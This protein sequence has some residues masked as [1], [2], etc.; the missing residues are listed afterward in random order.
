MT[1]SI[2]KMSIDYYLEHAATGDGAT[3]DLTSYYTETKAP[4]GTWFG[5]G[6]T[7]LSGLQAGQKVS[8]YA[9]RAVYEDQA[10]PATGQQLGRPR[11][12]SQ[13]T[14]KGART[15]AG[16]PQKDQRDGVAGFDL[17]FSPPKSVSALWALAGPELQDRLHAAHRQATEETLRWVEDNVL[18]SRA[19]HGGV[20][21]VQVKG[22]VA[23]MFDH[24]DSR[25]GD[26]QLHTHV[27]I[28]NRV[29]RVLD[30]HWVTLDSYTLHRHV[31]AISEMYNSVLFDRL[32][33]QVGAVA[34]PRTEADVEIEQVL[35]QAAVDEEVPAQATPPQRTELAGVPDRLIEEFSQRSAQIVARTDELVEVYR[36][37]TGREPTKRE[38]VRMRQQATLQNRPDKTDENG[39]TLP[40]KMQSW[41]RR[42]FLAGVEP[43]QV[44]RDA[45]GHDVTWISPESLTDEIRDRIAEWILTDNSARRTTFTRANVRA[46]AE[47]VLRLVRCRDV[48][49]RTR[50]VDEV[51]DRALAQSVS[52]SPTRSIAPETDDVSVILRGSSV[53]DHRRHAGVYTTV[54]VMADEEHLLA[55]TE[56]GTGPQLND[57]AVASFTEWRS[58]KGYALSADQLRAAQE[59]M[60]SARGLTAIIGPAGTG[61]TTTMAAITKVWQSEFGTDSVTGLAPSAVAA[62]V[63]ADEIGIDCDNTAKWLY[64]SVGEGA[65]R[66]AERVRTR[67]AAL[68]ALEANPGQDAHAERLRAQLAADYAMQAK[69]TMRQGQLLILDEASMISTAQLAQLSRQAERA[70]AK[71]L[72]VGDPA[73]LESVEAGGFLGHVER[74]LDHSIL[75]SVWRFKNEWE[76]AASLRLRR[77]DASVLKQYEK[78]GRLHGHPE[79]DPADLAYS[80]WQEDQASGRSSI[81]IASDNATVAELNERAHVD[82]VMA[83]TVDVEQTVILRQ[84]AVAG[85]GDVLLARRNDRQIRDSS[86]QFVTNGTRMTVTSILPDG[87]ATARV[88]SNGAE[89]RLDSDYLAGSVELGYATT[90]HRSQGV[91]VDTSHVVAGSGLR[92]ELFYEAMTRGRAANHAYVELKADADHSPD[93][94]DLLH[95]PDPGET[96]RAVLT[97]VVEN[98]S[99][100]RSAHEVRD[101]ELGWANDFGRLCFEADHLGWASRVSR[102][103]EWITTTFPPEVHDHIYSDEQWDSLVTA[104]PA[105]TFRGRADT[106]ESIGDIVRQ[107]APEPS[108]SSSLVPEVHPHTDDQQRLWN[109][110]KADIEDQVSARLAVLRRDPPDWFKEVEAAH[111]EPTQREQVM[112]DLVVW[113]AVSQQTNATSAYGTKPPAGSYLRP[114]WDRLRS[115]VSPPSQ[116][117]WND[118]TRD[119][120]PTA[121][122]SAIDFEIDRLEDVDWDL[123]ASSFGSLPDGP[124]GTKLDPAL[125]GQL[126]LRDLDHALDL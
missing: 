53:F 11:M 102:T 36:Q 28:A 111:P 76:R 50:L 91:T 60:S 66:R 103:K 115:V 105:R 29:Q 81:L 5:R 27:V 125:P 12:R 116:S 4:A 75:T 79:S 19:G 101:D 93:Q 26:P 20:A 68:A 96:P 9:V 87:S 21:H 10:D 119:T 89:I 84:E 100:E 104:D 31:V 51:V 90:A 15:P 39:A 99:A 1:V 2:S 52:L 94:W 57:S 124:T 33:D 22:M 13:P 49:S 114:Y 106:A 47:R 126:N 35:S 108:Q 62:G 69:F 92:R 23:S 118:S 3:R 37:E 109:K 43:A 46:S 42:A 121:D 17:T 95:A 85:V 70:G 54:E 117:N 44:I 113:R 41:R 30:D 48:G 14:P 58:E 8:E 120:V 83:G 122:Q 110:L 32:A 112:R 64:E 61:K 107:C 34:E 78:A 40:E 74:N 16:R 98:A 45:V 25:A 88:E 67:E 73:Q 6:L 63:L 82:R 56:S 7:G 65:A 55:R 38:I 24:W 86:G 59:T 18:Q 123:L 80:A 77:G 97:P 72:M 71:I